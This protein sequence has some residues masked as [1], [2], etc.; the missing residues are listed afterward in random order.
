MS[1]ENDSISSA[2]LKIGPAVAGSSIGL[3]DW[4]ISEYVSLLTGIYVA[5]QL[6][7]LIYDRLKKKKL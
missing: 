1:A 2:A 6:G 3:Q 4:G 5:V 7:L